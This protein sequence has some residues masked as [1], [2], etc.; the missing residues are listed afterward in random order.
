MPCLDKTN[1]RL[2]PVNRGENHLIGK[3]IWG[4]IIKDQKYHGKITS[5]GGELV[6]PKTEIAFDE[7]PLRGRKE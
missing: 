2:K 7:I 1:L 5:A 6:M 3:I 4:K